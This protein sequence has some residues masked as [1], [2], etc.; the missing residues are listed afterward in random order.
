LRQ[1]TWYLWA[2]ATFQNVYEAEYLD[3]E[4]T[5][6]KIASVLPGVDRM[7]AGRKPGGQP[8][9]G[10]LR[11]WLRPAKISV[12][13]FPKGPPH[14]IQVAWTDDKEKEAYWPKLT[15]LLVPIQ[16]QK[17]VTLT[18]LYMN[19]LKIPYPE[20]KKFTLAW[21][22]EK[23]SF[24]RHLGFWDFLKWKRI[25]EDEQRE[26]EKRE[27]QVAI[28]VLREEMKMNPEVM[29]LEEKAKRIRKYRKLYELS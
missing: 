6:E 25:Y 29:T 12:L 13:I 26:K 11:F 3:F 22:K 10:A 17:G 9:V 15:N 27:L 23:I 28:A 19:I 24:V 18:P 8:G 21:C 4:A 5:H 1:N 20:P 7:P 16:G 14:K 2:I